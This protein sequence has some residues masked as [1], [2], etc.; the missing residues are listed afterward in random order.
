MGSSVM[1][2]EALLH[3]MTKESSPEGQHRRLNAEK[4]KEW[5]LNISRA[6]CSAPPRGENKYGD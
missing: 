2:Q 5:V 6:S 3:G 1:G 4:E